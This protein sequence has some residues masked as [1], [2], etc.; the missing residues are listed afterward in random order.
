MS[1]TQSYYQAFLNRDSKYDGLFLTG[2]KTTGIFCRSSCPAKKPKFENCE[3]FKTARDA[4]AAGYRACKRCTPTTYPNAATDIIRTLIEAIEENPEKKWTAQD[5]KALHIDESTVRRQFKKRFGMTFGEYAR[6]KKMGMAIEELQSGEK[7]ISAQI[8]IGYESG[9]GFREA[10]TKLTGNSP[11]KS[12]ASPFYI[13]WTDSPLGPIV[14]IADKTH[15]H[16]LEFSDQSQLEAKL[17]KFKQKNNNAIL[18]PGTPEPIAQIE[19]ELDAYFK[20]QLKTF[21]TPTTATGTPFQKKVWTALKTIPYAETISYKQLAQKVGDP[22]ASRAVGSANGKNP[23]SIIV[24]CHRV[25]SA[26]DTLGGYAG[27]LARKQWL[28]KHESQN[29]TG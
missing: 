28:I 18:V 21:K 9:S 26:D 11:A 3:F 8:G 16:F 23:L 20:A 19:E 1:E 27:G 17:E 4:E 25:I 6:A 7:V 12:H 24:P 29:Y 13:A 14:L 10:F 22:N 15:L 5:F 2:V